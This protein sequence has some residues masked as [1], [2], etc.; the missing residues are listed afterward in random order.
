VVALADLF[1]SLHVFEQAVVVLAAAAHANEG[2]HLQSQRLA[3][4]FDGITVHDADFLHLL[5]AFGG[6]GGREAYS[7]A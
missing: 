6:G 3:V 5:E 1:E 4:D 2:H 7:A